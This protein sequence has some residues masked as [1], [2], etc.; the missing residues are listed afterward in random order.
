MKKVALYCR[1]STDTQEKAETIENQL[2]DLRK[3]YNK[4][5]IVKV[6][7]D[8]P[9]SGADLERKGL[10][11]LREGARKGLFNVV[12]V[13]A[14][15]RLA[16][17]VKWALVLRDELKES[18]VQIE[19]MGKERDDSEAGKLF[20]VLEAAMDEL[21]RERIK[22]RFVSGKKRRLGEG[23]MIG[24]YPPYGYTH[25]KRDKEKGADAYFK[26]NPKEAAV[27]KKI[28]KLYI[29][30]ESIFMVAKRLSKMGIKNRGKGGQPKFFHTSMIRK[31]LS[32]ESYIGNWYYGKTSPCVAKYHIHKIRKHKLTG[33]K[34]NPKSEWTLIKIPAIVNNQTFVIAQRILKKR[35]KQRGAESKFPV[36]CKGLIRCVDCGRLY[37]AKRQGDYR[38]Y[39]CPQVYGLDFN[40]PPCHSRS[41]MCHRLDAIVWDYVRCLIK[42]TVRVK[43]NLRLLKEKGEQDKVSNQ[44][45]YNSLLSEKE[46]LKDKTNKILE[47]YSDDSF[48]KEDLNAKLEEFKE[49]DAALDNQIKDIQTELKKID[50]MET[51]SQEVEKL[52]ILYQNSISSD[53]AFEQKRYTVQ[54]WVKEINLLKN[55]KIIIKV[56]LPE[57]AL[58]KGDNVCPI[59]AYTTQRRKKI[60][61]SAT[62]VALLLEAEEAGPARPSGSQSRKRPRVIAGRTTQGHAV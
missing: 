1:V 50:D 57:M 26:I 10:S 45:I 41:I 15:D 33:R 34:T 25:V 7:I 55:G 31:M 48:P 42:D 58:P 61:K 60:K 37:G 35:Y 22:R 54:K 56:N 44:E 6:Y 29:E 30:L 32:N 16:R 47:L 49:R 5:D 40:Q 36:L 51:I 46:K 23:K 20:S 17:D 24:A 19:V 28:F 12:G 43:K 9:A 18:G 11:E 21:E 62:C 4:K 27:V 8:N 52:C 39:R 3:V 53:P 14:S 13:W 2:K 38:I 59:S